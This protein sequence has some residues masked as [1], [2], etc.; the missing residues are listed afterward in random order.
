M[1]FKRKAVLLVVLLLLLVS[2]GVGGYFVVKNAQTAWEDASTWTAGDKISLPVQTNYNFT[3]SIEKDSIKV[4]IPFCVL[5][6]VAEKTADILEYKCATIPYSSVELTKRFPEKI[7]LNPDVVFEID[8]QKDVLPETYLNFARIDKTAITTTISEPQ[9]VSIS[10]TSTY[11]KPEKNFSSLLSHYITT[12]GGKAKENYE[13]LQLT[14]WK[15]DR[16]KEAKDYSA[17]EKAA[18]IAEWREKAWKDVNTVLQT[19]DYLNAPNSQ[20]LLD[21]LAPAMSYKSVY[22]PTANKDEKCRPGYAMNAATNIMYY[23]YAADSFDRGAAEKIA[24]A[25]R[26]RVEPF[27]YLYDE[28][29]TAY[30]NTCDINTDCTFFHRMEAY[31]YPMCPINELGKKN[32]TFVK[33][34]YMDYRFVVMDEA[35][36]NNP[37]NFQQVQEEHERFKKELLA[38]GSRRQ[39]NQ[40]TIPLIDKLCF[41]AMTGEREVDARSLESLKDLYITFV[42]AQLRISDVEFLNA[43]KVSNEDIIFDLVLQAT[44]L[45]PYSNAFIP[46]PFTGYSRLLTGVQL[47]DSGTDADG[48]W[49]SLNATLILLYLTAPNK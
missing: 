41:Y 25:L 6:E 49:S 4:T 34:L 19:S 30:Y 37:P 16:V 31:D 3:T 21:K 39:F 40:D 47:Q 2:I 43:G 33:S 23:T 22:C 5:Y 24:E 13:G 15:V 10:L 46:Q 8:T 42:Q 45:N 11:R 18:I 36:F 38:S 27:V 20:A 12:M 17:E 48:Y 26:N 35:Y 32:M 44:K 28:K 29:L 9:P 1:Q 14:E 7:K